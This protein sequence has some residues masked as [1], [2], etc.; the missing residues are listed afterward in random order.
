MT[1]TLAQLDTMPDAESA[2]TLAAC[3]GSSTWVAAMVAR[4]PFGSRETLLAVAEEVGL[5]LQPSDWLDAFAHHPR[6]GERQPAS[7]VSATAANW[8]Q[9]EQSASS[10]SSEDARAA[11]RE[12]NAEYEQ[13]FGFIFII[14]AN[15]RSANEILA[16]LRDR[17]TNE[18]DAEMF[19]AAREQRQITRQRLEK[20]IP[21]ARL[22][23]GAGS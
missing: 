12:A 14:C 1:L 9:G 13:R 17:L 2:F 5:A 18:P 23:R 19:I 7:L 3:C 15:G 21:A 22:S 11:L 8:S 10:M 4:R 16:A 20:L 6:I